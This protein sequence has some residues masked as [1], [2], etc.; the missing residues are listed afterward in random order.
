[1]GTLTLSMAEAG[2]YLTH[3][4]KLIVFENTAAVLISA[5]VYSGVPRPIQIR[6]ILF[7]RF[8]MTHLVYLGFTPVSATSYPISPEFSNSNSQDL[9]TSDSDFS[10]SDNNKIAIRTYIPNPSMVK[11]LRLQRGAIHNSSI[12]VRS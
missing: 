1:M 2:R 12:H 4:P 11:V 8:N 5:S 6:N 10:L 7:E 9:T 3:R